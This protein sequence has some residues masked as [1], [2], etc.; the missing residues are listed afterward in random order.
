MLRRKNRLPSTVRLTQPSTLSSPN[1]ILRF[2]KTEG[3]ESRLAIV[4][5][6]KVDKSAVARNRMRRL[7]ST[8]MQDNWDLL[9][10]PID[11]IVIVQKSFSVISS[12]EKEELVASLKSKGVFGEKAS[13]L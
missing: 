5:S 11:M 8:F 3:D 13:D 10:S 12:E 6:K 2:S 1:F 4:I 9:M 7:V